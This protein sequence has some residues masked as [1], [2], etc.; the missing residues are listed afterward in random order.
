MRSEMAGR[1]GVD[2]LSFTGG[3]VGGV[4]SAGRTLR[5]KGLGEWRNKSEEC[6]AVRVDVRSGLRGEQG[7]RLA[8]GRGWDSCGRRVVS[9]G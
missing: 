5:G 7:P 4:G 1:G 9:A 2:A 6:W 8:L 3:V